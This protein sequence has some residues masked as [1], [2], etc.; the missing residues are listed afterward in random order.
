MALH[1]PIYMDNHATT[2]TDP[3]VVDAMLPFFTEKFGNASSRHHCFGWEAEDAVA[4]ARAQVAALIGASEQ[5]IVF[6]SGGT[7][8]NNL[9]L[10]GV[11]AAYRRHGDHIIT[12]AVEHRSVLDPSRRL[13]NEGFRVTVLPVDC[14]G[15]VSIEDLARALDDRTILVSIMSANNEVGT[16]QPIAAIG[17][18]CKERGVLFHT[19]GVQALGK[20]P[21]DVEAMGID[22]MSLSAH[23]V[24]GPKGI[25][26]LYA[27]KKDPRV[28]LEPMID[29]GGHERGLRSGT[30]AVSSIVGFGHACELSRLEMGPESARLLG[31]RDRLEHGLLSGLKETFL[32]GP[33]GARLPGNLNLSFAHVDADALMMGLKNVAVSSGSAC[34]SASIEPSHVLKALGVGDDLA[35]G[36]IR[37]GLGRFNTALEVDYVIEQVIQQVN[38][39]RAL[40][41]AFAIAEA[42]RTSRFVSEARR[43]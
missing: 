32:N 25:G 27:R 22:L 7:E 6:T 8:S 2:R 29:G 40:S 11:A 43:S 23:K 33:P 4:A 18:L 24:Y 39:L 9:A 42:E 1:L 17:H 26:A 3:R 19:D 5:E 31:L 16:I 14:H 15:L 28:R 20:I 12:T 36:S 30:L 13:Q 41:P 38:R 35:R 34:T 37:F 10:K 21:M